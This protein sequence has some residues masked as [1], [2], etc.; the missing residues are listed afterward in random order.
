MAD[1]AITLQNRLALRIEEAAKAL[2]IAEGTVRNFLSQIPHFRLGRTLLFPVDGLRKWANDQASTQDDH[3]DK[4]VEE[5]LSAVE[6]K[7]KD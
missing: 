6:P 3:A 7:R 2:G 4:A 1:G 5:I